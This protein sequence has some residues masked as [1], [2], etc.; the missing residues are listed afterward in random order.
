MVIDLGVCVSDP[1]ELESFI[2]MAQQIGFTGFATHNITGDS[3]Q[4]LENGFSILK[5]VDV[6]GRGL[7]SIKKQVDI[8]RKNVMI[9]AVKLTSVETA[10]W[11]AE[12]HRVDL[13]TLDP[14]RE[15]RFRDT[16]ARLAAASNTALEI[17][18]EPLLHLTGLNRSKVLKTYRESVRTAISS[19]TQ[20]ILS[21]GAT[22]PLH[23]RSAMAMRHLGGLLGLE[24]E[25]AENVV[26]QVPLDIIER[27]RRRF[28][29]D[30]VTEGVEII[31]RES[32]K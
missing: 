9:V 28:S 11:A 29:S 32:D 3:D 23:M 30:Y 21:S 5:R 22:H 1:E 24:P 27:N 20:V 18:F 10:N 7:K 26:N 8:A 13:L 4:S 17:R 6:S 25:Y 16:T 31:R 19:G 14:S 2:Q 12:D 15:C